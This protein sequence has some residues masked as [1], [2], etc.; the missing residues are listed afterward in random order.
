MNLS[1]F[2]ID[3]PIFAGVI[4]VLIFLAGV[5]SVFQLPIS[6][7][8]EVVP[9]TV[10]V[11]AQ[12]HG[13]N[14]LRNIIDEKNQNTSFAYNID[15]TLRSVG[16]GNTTVPTPPVTYSY[17]PNYERV[18]SMTDGTGT[19]SYQYIPVASPPALGA[20]SLAGEIGPPPNSTVGS[21][22]SSGA[23][24]SPTPTAGPPSTGGGASRPGRMTATRCTRPATTCCRPGKRASA[25]A[26]EP[27][28]APCGG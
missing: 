20:G 8:P 1:R 10:V 13:A 26:P 19:T 25:V 2:F 21:P 24:R 27:G 12:F 9:P 18:T 3:R 17:D 11:K 16:F 4:S 5:I 6:E 28:A 14:G 23:G 7:Y 15:D 22:A